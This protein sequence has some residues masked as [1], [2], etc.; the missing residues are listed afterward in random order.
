MM[1]SFVLLNLSYSILISP[2]SGV[3]RDPSNLKEVVWNHS[4]NQVRC[5]R[6]TRDW[7]GLKPTSLEQ[8]L[9]SWPPAGW[10]GSVT[11]DDDE[12]SHHQHP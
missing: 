1:K 2:L 11:V 6:E 7:S 12:A 9:A 8:L 10:A 5:R 3:P 4:G